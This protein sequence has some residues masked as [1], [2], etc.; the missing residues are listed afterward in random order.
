MDAPLIGLTTYR[1][2]AAWGV[3]HTRAD[4]LPTE[5]AAAVEAA[6]GIP[7]LLPPMS[8]PGAAD[9]V[10][11][12]IDALVVSGGA[13]V[14][15]GQY[16]AEPHERTS[17]WQPERDV[18]ELALLSA[19]E[20]TGLP[21]LGICRGMQLMAVHGGGT[22]DQHTP[23]LVGHETHSPGGD[24]YGTVEVATT[25]GSR[26]ATLVGA[27]VEVSCHHHQSV[28]THPGFT[29]VARASDGTVEAMEAA[30]DRFCLAVQWHPE[31]RVEVGLMAGLVEAAR[32]HAVRAGD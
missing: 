30:G 6:G 27:Q 23:D 9:R 13:D 3:W 31:T 20:E 29:A 17:G 11:S 24:A 22:L 2:Q 14:D 19:A 21:V 26:L 5:Y 32:A 18:W 28:A 7:L 16:G 25:V 12:R 10:V 1:Q 8:L 4:L 15:P